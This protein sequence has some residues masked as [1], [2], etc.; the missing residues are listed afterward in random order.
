V[1]RWENAVEWPLLG[2]ALA[3]LAAYAWPILDPDLS[4]ALQR[5]CDVVTW[6]AWA[7]F[8]VDFA[9]RLT[10][11]TNRRRY[12]LRH[13]HDLAVIALPLLRPLRLL[14]LL[15]V[16]G[17]LNRRAGSSLRG[18][19]VV[20]V[21]GATTL[22]TAIASLAMLDAE[23]NAPDANITTVGDAF[24]WGAT[25]ITTVG[26]GDRF[27]TTAEGRIVA[28]GLMLGGIALLG[29]VTAT[30]ASWIID[31]VR[32]E[33]DAERAATWAQVEALMA[34]VRSLNGQGD[35]RSWREPKVT[36]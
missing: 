20:Y 21:V 26:Y 22:L 9:V 36:S 15:T 3:F 19:V 11:A 17:A 25:T 10:L 29:V 13:L 31:R 4:P 5:L 2:A 34:E 33:N 7:A 18:R 12:F 28:F 1:R 24:W 35:T 8:A 30:L 23:R 32:E 16:L 14:R 27:P 6:T